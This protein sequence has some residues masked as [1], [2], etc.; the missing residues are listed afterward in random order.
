MR[1]GDWSR[2]HRRKNGARTDL[3]PF[4][5]IATRSRIVSN[6]FTNSACRQR[7][8]GALGPRLLALGP[9]LSRPSFDEDSRSSASR[10]RRGAVRRAAR[11]ARRPGIAA[12]TDRTRDSRVERPVARA[13]RRRGREEYEEHAR[14]RVY[15]NRRT[16]STLEIKYC[17]TSA[18]WE[19][20]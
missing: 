14:I 9:R 16:N 1:K 2:G 18:R 6:L 10:P 5:S 20:Q 3:G 12:V 17:R 4:D 11:G 19:E 15:S 7:R 8:W 13:T